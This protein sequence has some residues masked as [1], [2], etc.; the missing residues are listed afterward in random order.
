LPVPYSALG[1][2]LALFVTSISIPRAAATTITFPFQNITNN[3]AGDADI[4]EAQ[5]FMDVSDSGSDVLFTFR[6]VGPEASNISEIYFDDGSLLGISMILD[7]PPSVDFDL[8]ASPPNLPGGGSI[9]PPFQTTAGFSASAENPAPARG[10]GPGESVGIKFSLINGKVYQDVIDELLATTV[11][12]G[13]HVTSFESGGSEAFINAPE[14]TT[15]ALLGL[16]GLLLVALKR[17][18]NSS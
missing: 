5:L 2:A 13:I 7:S 3:N 4:G 9:S 8:G 11:R 14:P 12:V 1:C 16:G 17:R 18:R 10:V 15:A 6:N